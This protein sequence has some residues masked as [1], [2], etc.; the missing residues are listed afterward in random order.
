MLSWRV[1]SEKKEQIV[2][3][4]D[5]LQECGLCH[6]VDGTP[7]SSVTW[8][9]RNTREQDPASSGCMLAKDHSNHMRSRC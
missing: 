5:F 9:N 1:E 6:V 2:H 4:N 8:C 7:I 3:L